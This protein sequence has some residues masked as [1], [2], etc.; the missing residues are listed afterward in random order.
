MSHIPFFFFEQTMMWWEKRA[1][2]QIFP[3]SNIVLFKGEG[4]GHGEG[5]EKALDGV[6]PELAE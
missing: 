1:S 5:L 4:R 6:A 2:K 3:P